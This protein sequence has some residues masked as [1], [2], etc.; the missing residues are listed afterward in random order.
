MLLGITAND[1]I[2]ADHPIR[3][4]KRL[5]DQALTTLSPTLCAMCAPFLPGLAQTS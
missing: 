3:A 2:P 4:I 5:V 1:L